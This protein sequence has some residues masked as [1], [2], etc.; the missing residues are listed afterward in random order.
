MQEGDTNILVLKNPVYFPTHKKIRPHNSLH[1]KVH[2][3]PQEKSIKE[4]PHQ[5]YQHLCHIPFVLSA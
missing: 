3:N 5:G 4:N 2:L 1:Q